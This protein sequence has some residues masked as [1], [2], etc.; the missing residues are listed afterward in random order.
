MVRVR[1]AASARL[2]PRRHDPRAAGARDPVQALSA[3]HPP[4]VLLPGALRLP[5]RRVPGVR[6]RRGALDRAPVLPRADRGRGR[7]SRRGA[8]ERAL[9]GL[10]IADEARPAE[11]ARDPD[12]RGTTA[13]ALDEA[14]ALVQWAGARFRRAG[15]EREPVQAGGPG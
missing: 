8:V 3:G 15:A 4:D 10:E 9:H 2:R 11:V 12:I 7:A 6:G 13:L 14:V 5:R 1:G